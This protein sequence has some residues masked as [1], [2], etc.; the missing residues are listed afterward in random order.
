MVLASDG[1]WELISSQ[2]IADIV[3]AV[4]EGEDG[5]VQ[6]ICDT[7][8]D[9]ASYMWKVE[10]GDYRDDITVIVLALPWA[11]EEVKSK[12]ATATVPAPTA[13]AA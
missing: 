5:S 6:A 2:Q 4:I 3:A 8:V 1:L 10:E 13:S 12:V 9:Q 11:T 7:L